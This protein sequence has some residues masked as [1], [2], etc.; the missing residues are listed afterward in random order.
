MDQTQGRI[1]MGRKWPHVATNCQDGANSKYM[2]FGVEIYAAK[3][4]S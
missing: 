4:V 1:L 3:K 2:K